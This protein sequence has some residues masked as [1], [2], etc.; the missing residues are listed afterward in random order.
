MKIAIYVPSWP[1]GAFANGIVTYAAQII[2]AL[3]Q[4]GHEVF[5]LT[6]NCT[7]KTIDP[8][9]VDLNAIETQRSPLSRLASRLLNSSSRVD[10]FG[11]KLLSTISMLAERHSIDVLEIEESF[12]WAFIIAQATIVPVV[13]RL[14]GP[15]FLNG[16][17]D[18]SPTSASRTRIDAEG[19]G[20]QAATMITAPSA[21]V[22]SNVRT[23]YN[24]KLDLA[25]V[26]PNPMDVDAD[27]TAWRLSACDPNRVLYVGRFDRRKGGDIVLRAFAKLAETYPDLRLSFVGPDKGVY[28]DGELLSFDQFVRKNIPD[29]CWS[30]IDFRGQLSHPAVM[31]LRN[32]HLFT[33]VASQFEIL[34]YAVLEAM[35]LGCPVIASNVGGI[36]EL[37]TDQKTGLLFTN[38]SVEELTSACRKLLD[39]HTLAASLGSQAK[40]YCTASFNVQKITQETLSAYRDSI[41]IYR[42]TVN[43]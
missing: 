6:P 12:G 16:V 20:I 38:Q 43:S 41:E 5:V 14:H 3:R 27:A 26:I 18:G 24:L 33:I 31:A 36:P 11:K 40:I 21:D 13:V 23:Q 2:P 32:E 8:Y 37:I 22:L 15:W 7:S 25:R 30:R 19:R 17:F 34:P 28:E 10:D 9:T 35:A 1:P 42:R 29:P 39:D 4:L